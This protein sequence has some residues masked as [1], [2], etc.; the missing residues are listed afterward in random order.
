MSFFPLLWNHE[1]EFIREDSC[2]IVVSMAVI[3]DGKSAQFERGEIFIFQFS[4]A[5]GY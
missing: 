4:L 2:E 1:S 5:C 3:S